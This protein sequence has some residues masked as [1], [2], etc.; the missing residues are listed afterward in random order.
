M[1]FTP[2]ISFVLHDAARPLSKRSGQRSRASDAQQHQLQTL[3]L[4][5]SNPLEACV[6]PAVDRE[7]I[8]G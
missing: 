5:K 7:K 2:N 8:H 3:S 4:I 1:S 6:Q